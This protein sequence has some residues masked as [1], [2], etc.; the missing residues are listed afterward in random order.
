M[1]VSSNSICSLP[2]EK[3]G[4]HATYL[5]NSVNRALLESILWSSRGARK[6]RKK[7]RGTMAL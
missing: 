2:T 7:T 5:K 3:V 6:N 1:L 4:L